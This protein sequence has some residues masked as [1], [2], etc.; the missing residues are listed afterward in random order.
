MHKKKMAALYTKEMQF[1]A[2]FRVKNVHKMDSFYPKNLNLVPPI[3]KRLTNML[4]KFE[5]IWVYRFRKMMSEVPK[6]V[7]SRKTRLKFLLFI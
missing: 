4:L 1:H 7:V 6:N 3:K 2:I 5:F